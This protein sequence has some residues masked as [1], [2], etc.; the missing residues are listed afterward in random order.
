LSDPKPARRPLRAIPRLDTSIAAT[1]LSQTPWLVLAAAIAFLAIERGVHG[2]D[3]VD[4]VAKGAQ[5]LTRSAR[6]PW[7][8]RNLDEVKPIRPLRSRDLEGNRNSTWEDAAQPASQTN[9]RRVAGT[10]N[11]I[12]SVL[13]WLL[14]GLF[15]ALLAFAL[16]WAFL[17]REASQAQPTN[18]R[19]F[20]VED[21]ALQI[22]QLPFVVDASQLDFLAEARRCFDA[23]DYPRAAIYLFSYQLVYLDQHRLIHLERGRTNRQYLRQL[24]R[25]PRLQSLFEPTMILFEEVYFGGRPV[26]RSQLEAAWQRLD[27]FHQQLES[28]S[29]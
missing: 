11:P 24:S 12:L 9:L 27:A 21:V 28:H 25:T 20:A 22:E 23:G 16:G 17:R 19:K 29:A 8:D 2:S 13:A 5:S 10:L 26:A 6:F 15:A 4:W 1:R 3:E 18:R 14:L 7:Y